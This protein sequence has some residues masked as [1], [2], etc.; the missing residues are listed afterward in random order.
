M[1]PV[2]LLEKLAMLMVGSYGWLEE[3]IMTKNKK[4]FS[5]PGGNIII[6][7]FIGAAINSFFPAY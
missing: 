5:L 6:P 1:L 3:F 2:L 7:M 4:Y